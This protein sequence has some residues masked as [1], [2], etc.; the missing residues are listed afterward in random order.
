MGRHPGRVQGYSPDGGPGGEAPVPH[1]PH[2]YHPS[3]KDSMLLEYN[4]LVSAARMIQGSRGIL[5]RIKT[6]YV[7][8]S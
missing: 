7:D 4:A 8:G 5:S 1:Y 2:S 6:F 3:S